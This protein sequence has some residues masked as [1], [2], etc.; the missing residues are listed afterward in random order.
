M[1][2]CTAASF[3]N[4]VVVAPS[5]TNSTR[6][7]KPDKL[8]VSTE[9][10]C[11][12]H[13]WRQPSR[14]YTRKVLMKSKLDNSLS[15]LW[16]RASFKKILEKKAYS[17]GT[18]SPTTSFLSTMMRSWQ[19]SGS[20]SADMPMQMQERRICSWTGG[21]FCVSVARKCTWTAIQWKE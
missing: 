7:G 16:R 19:T 10:A 1:L 8:S 6:S 2:R 3:S 5:K 18:S 4:S 20:L 17:I 11:G 12:P 21:C 15:N 9:P 13:K 14:S